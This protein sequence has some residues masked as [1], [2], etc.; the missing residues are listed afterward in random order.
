MAC[1]TPVMVGE[2]SA[3][4]CP[5]ACHLMLVEKVGAGDTAA[6][7]ARRLSELRENPHRL[8][9]LRSEVAKFSREHWSWESTAAEYAKLLD[10]IEFHKPAS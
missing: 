4:G 2:D 5:D 6:R 7:W 8:L 9:A 1:G 3:S 10:S